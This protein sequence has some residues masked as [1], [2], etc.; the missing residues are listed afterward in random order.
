MQQVTATDTKIAWH[1][2]GYRNI[3]QR[4][5]NVSSPWLL[6]VFIR[7]SATHLIG[8]EQMLSTEAEVYMQR[9]RKFYIQLLVSRACLMS[10]PQSSARAETSYPLLSPLLYY[11]QVEYMPCSPEVSEATGAIGVLCR[12]IPMAVGGRLLQSSPAAHAIAKR[13]CAEHIPV[14]PGIEEQVAAV[15]VK[16]LTEYV[17]Y[18]A[19]F[20]WVRRLLLQ[21]PA[22]TPA[23][24]F[25]LLGE[26]AISI[27]SH[28][29]A[30]VGTDEFTAIEQSPENGFQVFVK[31]MTR[32]CRF[33]KQSH[34][35]SVNAVKYTFALGSMDSGDMTGFL[36]KS[37][38]RME[39][40]RLDLSRDMDP[41]PDEHP[42]IRLQR[43][44]GIF[45]HSLSDAAF[46][47]D[48]ME[49]DISDLLAA[50]KLLTP[51]PMTSSRSAWSPGTPTDSASIEKFD[52]STAH[53][54]IK[55]QVY[56]AR[57]VMI[58]CVWQLLAG[59]W[60][61]RRVYFGDVF[62][63]E[64]PQPLA[65]QAL[66]FIKQSD[67]AVP[68]TSMRSLFR[69]IQTQSLPDIDREWGGFL[70]ASAW[71][72]YRIL[73]ERIEQ[74]KQ[75]KKIVFETSRYDVDVVEPAHGY[76]ATR[77]AAEPATPQLPIPKR[78]TVYFDAFREVLTAYKHAV[79]CVYWRRNAERGQGLLEIIAR[80]VDSLERTP[81]G[82]SDDL[83][84]LRICV[85]IPIVYAPLELEEQ[86]VL[87][88][89]DSFN[90]RHTPM[91]TRN[92]TESL[93][94]RHRMPLVTD[95]TVTFSEWLEAFFAA[96][97][98]VRQTP[99]AA[100][101]ETWAKTQ[102]HSVAYAKSLFF[103]LPVT[104]TVASEWAPGWLPDEV[105]E[106]VIPGNGKEPYVPR[107]NRR[108]TETETRSASSAYNFTGRG[109]TPPAG[110]AN[111]RAAFQQHLKNAQASLTNVSYTRNVSSL[112]A[113][114]APAAT[115]AA[116]VVKYTSATLYLNLSDA[117]SDKETVL[118]A[119]SIL[120]GIPLCDTNP[121]AAYY[122]CASIPLCKIT[123]TVK[124][125]VSGVAYGATWGEAHQT[126]TPSLSVSAQKAPPSA[127]YVLATA[128]EQAAFVE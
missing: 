67:I 7:A 107:K 11:K 25:S 77:G 74:L 28:L 36:Q 85:C 120:H 32:W 65:E 109:V 63:G 55:E 50:R 41:I 37:R 12:A 23:I 72:R 26:E 76:S 106:I 111:A 84:L 58:P 125:Q 87:R 59:M 15:T 100:A 105:L 1:F 123:I 117:A 43:L 47:A 64:T 116:P 83:S 48:S 71:A 70:C 40:F 101:I 61:D 96:A 118:V 31:A 94:N 93:A 18:W 102:T 51:L 8:T 80:I 98:L 2:V 66:Q 89:F 4:A 49:T 30:R 14:D 5:K 20:E 81:R 73:L 45:P 108:T 110:S 53:P 44:F 104:A 90:P 103:A 54:F 95:G 92:I 86:I 121:A 99:G 29:M 34:P 27:Q 3:P 124:A 10:P 97:N 114:G 115:G 78:S 62:P 82:D 16:V 112:P 6:A 68:V 9:Y 69:S 33:Y 113:Q 60:T 13:L 91:P 79:Y 46:S 128:A 126:V 52:W 75:T 119:L 39:Q 19:Y 22:T 56:S 17:H 21:L 35:A 24:D 122:Q 127:R 57:R 42:A 88:A 38:L